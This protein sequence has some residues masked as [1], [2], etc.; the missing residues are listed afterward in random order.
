MKPLNPS[1]APMWPGPAAVSRQHTADC[2]L[3]V[4]RNYGPLCSSHRGARTK[5]IELL[6]A[7]EASALRDLARDLQLVQSTPTADKIQAVLVG[8]VNRRQAHVARSELGYRELT[9]GPL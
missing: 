1:A 4:W 5:L 3:F 7:S 2:A 6:K 9:N 8:Y